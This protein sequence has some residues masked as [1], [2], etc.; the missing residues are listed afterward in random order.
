HATFVD[1]TLGSCGELSD[2]VE[3]RTWRLEVDDHMDVLRLYNQGKKVDK[4]KLG[5]PEYRTKKEF[6]H[7]F[8]KLLHDMGGCEFA[9]QYEW[10]TCKSQPNCLKRNDSEGDPTQ[11]LVAVDFRAGLALLPFLPMSPGDFKLILQGLCR[12]SLV[13]FDRGDLKKL[14]SFIQAHSH[15]FTDMM[16]LYDEL[17]E[18]THVYRNSIPDIT[19]NHVRL[20][21]SRKLWSQIF[22]STRLGWRV[23]NLLDDQIKERFDKSGVK[24]VLFYVLGAIP[25]LG[26]VIRK[27]WGR[28]DWRGHYKNCVTNL[29]YFKRAMRGKSIEAAIDWHRS[30]RMSEEQAQKVSQSY[31][32]FF[33]HLPFSFLPVGLH[34]FFTNRKFVLAVLYYYMVRPIRL[35]FSA[36]MR[37]QWLRDML[38]KGQDNHILADDDARIIE[39]Q[40]EEPYIQK[41]LKSLAVH[42]CTLPVTQIVSVAVSWIYVHMHPELSTAE[43]MAA[44]AAILVLFQ[45][46]PVSPGSLVRGLYVLYLVIRE[47][48]FKDYNIAV[49]LGFFKYIGYLAFPI[50]MAYR[51]PELARFMSGQWAT[52]AVHIVPVFGEKGALLEHWVYGVFYNWPLTIRRRMKNNAAL[53]AS[54][55]SRYWHVVPNILIGLMIFSFVNLVLFKYFGAQPTLSQNWW[56]GAIFALYFG[57]SVVSCSLGASLVNRIISASI[58]G[59]ASGGFYPLVF[60]FFTQKSL[61][62][63]QV[64]FISGIW[65]AFLFIVFAVMGAVI[66]ELTQAD[67][68]LLRKT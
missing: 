30:G 24:T 3:G 33:S 6:M 57:S 46:T 2:W 21:Y 50:Q 36:E 4:T 29:S 60:S 8:V 9:R 64:L 25:V 43:A 48:N 23:K 19:H 49:F 53:R 58:W 45:I 1:S 56:F 12:G 31:L 37:E 22:S 15:E 14:K 54:L 39:A 61:V 62:M 17:E 26:R 42:V 65:Y 52:S 67:P 51:Y 18:C 32:N 59:L 68:E 27:I 28:A 16:P 55:R 5:S 47:R 44:V 34:K 35:Y 66:N 13:Q 38:K 20:L 63:T 7:D 41:Y 40:I 10:S 11:G